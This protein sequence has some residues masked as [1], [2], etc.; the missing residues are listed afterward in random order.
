MPNSKYIVIVVVAFV[1]VFH[2]FAQAMERV[3]LFRQS[4]RLQDLH[5]EETWIEEVQAATVWQIKNIRTANIKELQQQF[6]VL[7]SLWPKGLPYPTMKEYT[8]RYLSD[9]QDDAKWEL[10]STY[11]DV[12]AGKKVWTAEQPFYSAFEFTAMSMQAELRD[13]DEKAQIESDMESHYQSLLVKNG[14]LRALR[15]IG[16][17][18]GRGN[19][20]IML[21]TTSF[22][23][24]TNLTTLE[25]SDWYDAL[26]PWVTFLACVGSV[27]TSEPMS[28]DVELK[29]ML[30]IFPRK[31]MK[32][33]VSSD[34][35]STPFTEVF[36]EAKQLHRVLDKNDYWLGKLNEW[37][38]HR[39]GEE[40]HG[41]SWIELRRK[42]ETAADQ[43]ADVRKKSVGG[44]IEELL[45]SLTKGEVDEKFQLLT[46]FSDR[47]VEVKERLRPGATHRAETA[48][49]KMLRD[50]WPVCQPTTGRADRSAEIIK[51]LSKVEVAEA[52]EFKAEVV[53][54][55][56]ASMHKASK[57]ILI[58]TLSLGVLTFEHL[59]RVNQELIGCK[60]MEKDENTL[61]LLRKQVP[62]CYQTFISE[63]KLKGLGV[64]RDDA[65][66]FFDLMDTLFQ[67]RGVIEHRIKAK[68]ERKFFETWA[69]K[70]MSTSHQLK[71]LSAETGDSNTAE[72]IK[73]IKLFEETRNEMQTSIPKD[74]SDEHAKWL[75]ELADVII[76]VLHKSADNM[77][78]YAEAVLEAAQGSMVASTEK[79]RALCGGCTDPPGKIWHE[80]RLDGVNIIQHFKETL[81]L[82]Q[83]NLLDQRAKEL[84]TNIEV[85]QRDSALVSDYVR[86]EKMPATI[87][88]DIQEAYRVYNRSILTEFEF[89]IMR[90]FT[91]TRADPVKSMTDRQLEYGSK[92]MSRRSGQIFDFLH[93]TTPDIKFAC[94]KFVIDQK[95]K[96]SDNK[97]PGK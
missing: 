52:E 29:D 76:E 63:I 59:K 3:A 33:L 81:D 83:P 75:E 67:E 79:C 57:D 26:S 77:E 96:A 4:E 21:C 41:P 60:T 19:S 88:R 36:P 85:Y 69:E 65:Q 12:F 74:F 14:L 37:Y 55:S 89:R 86:T 54:A 2:A 38:E 73:T 58:A 92:C 87:E 46:S 94:T 90:L 47:I 24:H 64:L 80:G 61:K 72:I 20:Q 45:N 68:S 34:A 39:S 48:A 18:D 84:K 23:K 78:P 62:A 49:W 66:P 27:L 30:W 51:I 44:G 22:L 43:V 82:F 15:D 28:F 40:L 56:A 50:L 7:Q 97:V 11:M 17:D 31:G 5:N 8:T 25:H 71:L 32:P 10:W 53:S 42:L 9:L 16:S 70:L 91:R 93:D 95:A 1:A 35:G 6:L 13:G